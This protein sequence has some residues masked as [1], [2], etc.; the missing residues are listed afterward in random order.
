MSHTLWI[1]CV[2][3]GYLTMIISF[4]LY[5]NINP[6]VFIHKEPNYTLHK[7]HRPTVIFGK[8][9]IYD[10]NK[11]TCPN[12]SIEETDFRTECPQGRPPKHIYVVRHGGR[13]DWLRQKRGSIT[14]RDWL[15]D[16]KGTEKRKITV[17]SKTP[18]FHCC[19]DTYV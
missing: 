14:Q 12:C 18:A 13:A 6:Q 7:E 19:N 8:N 16:E 10:W 4:V 3:L 5:I 11:E 17:S 2:F 9:T 15:L 1:P